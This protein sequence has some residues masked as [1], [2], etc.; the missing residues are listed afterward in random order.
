MTQIFWTTVPYTDIPV[1]AILFLIGLW[2][3]LRNRAT[4]LASSAELDGTIGAGNPVVMEF[5]SNT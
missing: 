5:F 2:F 4:P 1:V 3:V